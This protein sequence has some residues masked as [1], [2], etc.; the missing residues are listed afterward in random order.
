MAEVPVAHPTDEASASSMPG[1]VD[2]REQ[3]FA[4]MLKAK[5]SQGYGI[6]SQGDTEAVLFTRSRRRWFGLFAGHGAG[7]RQRISVDDQ[8]AAK[9]RKLSPNETGLTRQSE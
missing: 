5:V 2:T 1:A 9:T 3:K 8:G 4:Q 7:A 6:E